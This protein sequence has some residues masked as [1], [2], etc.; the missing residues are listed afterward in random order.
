[1]S[2]VNVLDLAD[3]TARTRKGVDRRMWVLLLYIT[4]R[5]GMDMIGLQ[6]KS[7]EVRLWYDGPRGARELVP[8]PSRV[9]PPMFAFIWRMCL[10]R[11]RDFLSK[12]GLGRFR[13]R[14]E[15]PLNWESRFRIKLGDGLKDVFAVAST[16]DNVSL[17]N[18]RLKDV[19]I[20]A[21]TT[22]DAII[23]QWATNLTDED[24]ASFE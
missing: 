20:T 19:T 18:L 4:I 17:L 15:P 1:M 2:D 9:V 12:L 6:S 7:D 22:S 5:D 14:E 16:V 8:V 3:F 11:R 23:Q 10:P 24:I 13:K 21:G